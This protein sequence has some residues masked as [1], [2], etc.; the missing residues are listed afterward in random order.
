MSAMPLVSELSVWFNTPPFGISSNQFFLIL[1]LIRPYVQRE[2]FIKP[3]MQHGFCL[4]FYCTGTTVR[5]HSRSRAV[6]KDL[7]RDAK[8]AKSEEDDVPQFGWRPFASGLEIA[9]KYRFESN[10]GGG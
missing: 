8:L 10:A 1:G 5:S 3:T 4:R 2:L 9:Q 6:Q 7:P